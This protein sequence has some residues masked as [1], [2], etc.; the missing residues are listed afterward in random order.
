MKLVV[1]IFLFMLLSM[2]VIAQTKQYEISVRFKTDSYDLDARVND[3]SQ[4][5]IHFKELIEGIAQDST[6][7]VETLEI[8][9][10]ASP[11]G[12][13]AYNK[14]LTALRS[15]AII[16]YITKILPLNHDI[17]KIK[18]G[19]ISWDKLLNSAIESDVP[20]KQQVIKIL[21]ENQTDEGIEQL[22]NIDNGLS[23]NYLYR[24]IFPTLREGI[25]AINVHYDSI[26]EYI[27]GYDVFERVATADLISST[28]IS[29]PKTEDVAAKPM[30]GYATMMPDEEK[31]FNI[32]IKTNLLYDAMT[33]INFQIEYPIGKSV[34]VAAEWICP[35]WVADNGN[36]DSKRSRLQIK[37]GNLE[38]K[39][40][41]GKRDNYELLT[42]WYTGV[43]AAGGS[44]DVEY[45]AKGYQV[46]SYW[47]MGLSGGYAHTI[48]K[49]KDLRLEYSL[50]LGFINYQF[51]NYE[52]H[53]SIME[54]WHS[55]KMYDGKG[56]FFGPTAAKVSLVWMLNVKYTKKGGPN[57]K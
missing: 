22:M 27:K 29:E 48:N 21:S 54:T 24:H 31:E 20:H 52:S 40:W 37:N 8:T 9:S 2:S 53:Y 13:E 33:M 16:D 46:S 11:E 25:L 7:Y 57:E 41:F 19:G 47:G 32:A 35:W 42:G 12:G 18:Q 45:Q 49:A 30:P 23:Y 55:V 34:S 6:T 36:S 17:I 56:I 28:K 50:G 5:I 1:N 38:A 51:K 3:N 26:P 15:D 10:W 4:R 39:Y 14:Q 44:C 43:Y